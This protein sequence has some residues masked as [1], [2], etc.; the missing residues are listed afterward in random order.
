MIN[1]YDNKETNFNHNGLV[2]LDNCRS[3]P[4]TEELNGQYEL[5]LEYPLDSRGKWQYF[6][7]GNIIKADGQLFRMYRKVK[8]LNGIKVNARHIFYDLLFNLVDGID[9]RALT[10]AAALDR[11]MSNTAYPHGFTY[12]TDITDV[13]SIALDDEMGDIINQ[14][15]VE[16]IFYLISLYGG[17]LVRDNYNIKWL[18]HR[19]KDRGVLIAYGKNIKG[20]E[21]DLNL[22]GFITRIKPIGKDGLTL[23]EKYV[24]S[25]NINSFP[26]PIIKPLEFNDCD[27]YDTL[28]A[29]AQKH[30]VD[31]KCDIPEANYK[32][33][34]IEL[35]KTEEYKHYKVLETLYLGDIATIKHTRLD[36]NLKCQVIKIKK[37]AITGRI[38]NIELGV[39]KPNISN[40]FSKIDSALKNASNELIK[41]K[42]NLQAAIDNA[43][44]LLTTALGGYVLKRENEIL[45]MDTNDVNT[46]QKVWRWNINGLG[47][48]STGY[49]GNFALA[50]TMD[51]K[52]VADFIA[53]GILEGALLKAG[54]VKTSSLEVNAKQVIETTVPNL[55]KD[56]TTNKNAISTIETTIEAIPG[57]IDSKV[58][59]ATAPINQN[60]SGLDG[61]LKTAEQKITPDAIVNTVTNSETYKSDIES[62]NNIINAEINDLQSQIDG[63]I[64]TWFYDGAPKLTNLPANTWEDDVTKDIHLGDLYYDNLTGYAYRF[65]KN[66]NT[67]EWFRITDTD[68]T[69]ALADAK[70]AQDT[71]DGKRR[72]FTTT[73]IPPYDPGDL[74]SQGSTG[75]LMKCKTAKIGGQIYS[76]SDW[77]KASKYTDDTLANQANNTANNLRDKTIPILTERVSSAE[78]K[79]TDEAIIS[80]VTE[81]NTYKSYALIPNKA[82]LGLTRSGLAIN[83]LQA[84]NFT[85]G[86]I[87]QSNQLVSVESGDV[88][89]VYT[90]DLQVVGGEIIIFDKPVTRIEEAESQIKQTAHEITLRLTMDEFESYRTQTADLIEEKVKAAD[91]E[92][93]KTQAAGLI[94]EKVSSGTFE[95]YKTQTASEISSKVASTDFNSFQSTITQR[96]SN[97]ELSVNNKYSSSL[98]YTDDAKS[99]LESSINVQ[100]GRIDVVS[101]K[102]NIN[103][104][105]FY[106]DGTM[107]TEG[108]RGDVINL[109]YGYSIDNRSNGIRIKYNDSN[110]AIVR[111]G[112]VGFYI[113]GIQSAEIRSDGVY[114]VENGVAY[115][116]GSGGGTAV[117][118]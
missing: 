31:T 73:P 116:L 107:Q 7:E 66:I 65:R 36:I 77:E 24:D 89:L 110:Y 68:I 72:V 57:Q 33:D 53:T 55:V 60:I 13:N 86:T 47:Y 52:I 23:P 10:G 83:P 69:K 26:Y 105:Y 87:F 39:F 94:S 1:I 32:I 59:E 8:N 84:Y 62:I 21:E 22:E 100:A 109:N 41:T 79:I 44:Q 56:N 102:V 5:E 45:I 20:I 2:V 78:Q 106:S 91:F 29:A 49:N 76:A 98:N 15:P 92:S 90:T 96:A 95:T 12:M 46:A 71:A 85:A 54:S 111:N 99:E 48:S 70:K 64:T 108:L 37:D 61:R 112:N 115:K 42:T 67:Y 11:L 43:T 75:D 35:S 25:P 63:N 30:F 28:R 88:D 38:E 101:S 80:T 113:N 118:S 104:T 74:W 9:I 81:S 27:N 51:G 18:Q 103:G 117:F 17:E 93:Y 6:L 16:S 97:I 40:A 14:N 3:C 58:S 114:N 4:V 34:F 50:M 19:G 82:A